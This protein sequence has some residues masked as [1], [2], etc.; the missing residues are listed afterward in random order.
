MYEFITFMCWIAAIGGVVTFAFLVYS[1]E[2]KAPY[3]ALLLLPIVCII[4]L[5]RLWVSEESHYLEYGNPYVI[6]GQVKAISNNRITIYNGNKSSGN[7][8]HTFLKSQADFKGIN[9]E[10][11]V[12]VAYLSGFYHDFTIKI[13]KL[14][15]VK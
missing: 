8:S 1:A 10:D 14:V 9:E 12:R 13:E 3:F 2:R 11:I 7:T 15:P 6:Y 4:G 5:W